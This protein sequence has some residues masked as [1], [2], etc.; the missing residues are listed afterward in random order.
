MQLA[1]SPEFRRVCIQGLG[2]V[3]AAMAVAVASARSADGNILYHVTG[4]DCETPTGCARVEAISCGKFPFS[5]ADTSL[6][7]ALRL[8]HETGNLCATTD[9]SAYASAD[10]VIIDVALDIPFKDEEPQFQMT[11]LEKAVRS[12]VQKVP[13]GA[14]ILVETTVPPGTC[15]KVVMPI[16]I[17][18]LQLRG[19]DEQAVHL[20]HSFERV[21]PG[22]TYLDSITHFW[23]VYSGATIEAADA[24]EQ[25]LSS[26]VDVE[27]YPLT[28][29]SSMTASE[30]AKVMEN[31]YRAVNIALI[32]EW[33]KYAELVGID[34]FEV[35]DAIRIRP[36]H[37]N[38]RYPGLGVGGYCLTKDPAFAPAA[39][40][41]LFNQSNLDFP[42]SQ[43]AMQVNQE[44]PTHAVDRLESL[45]N[46]SFENKS[47]LVLGASY[48][49]EVG[50][51][52]NSPVE[53]LVKALEHGG[54]RVLIFDPFVYHWPEINRTLLLEY[55][56]PE[57]LDAVVLATAHREFATINLVEW[58]GENR[59]V[60]LDTVNVV[61][62]DQRE[63]CLEIGI[64]FESVG[65]G[66]GS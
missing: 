10:V 27:R 64:Q 61:T 45:L 7:E 1:S 59:P 48:R 17:E 30:T 46:G 16:L 39:V 66:I 8:A 3:G 14:L 4:V 41:Q 20:A 36:T 57:E 34:L 22:N 62:S 56:D 24:C 32:D 54:A 43:L 25:F 12:V 35:I 65:R 15:Q 21:M 19:L 51:T 5:T 18:E 47:I 26:I 49:Q 29:L 55:P 50:D 13:E 52:R 37:S 2:F 63:R 53:V 31:T 28:R 9:E 33:T 40:R 42:F 58:L 6:H 44:M 38:I 23:R 60:I 11:N